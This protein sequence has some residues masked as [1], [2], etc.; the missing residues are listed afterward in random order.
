MPHMTLFMVWLWLLSKRFQCH[1]FDRLWMNHNEK[2]ERLFWSKRVHNE[3]MIIL[4]ESLKT[5]KISA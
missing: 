5:I 3:N 1:L 2:H 4:K